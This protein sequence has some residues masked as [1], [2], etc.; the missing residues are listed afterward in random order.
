MLSMTVASV[1]SDVGTDSVTLPSRSTVTWSQ[2]SI[3]SLR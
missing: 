2:M 1:V 3:I